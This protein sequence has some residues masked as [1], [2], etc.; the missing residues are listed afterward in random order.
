MEWLANN[1]PVFII[2]GGF[3]FAIIGAATDPRNRKGAVDAYSED[4]VREFSL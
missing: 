3:A 4:E 1:W 2:L